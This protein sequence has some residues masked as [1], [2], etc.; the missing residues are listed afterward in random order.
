VKASVITPSG[1]I[2]HYER[3]EIPSDKPWIRRVVCKPIKGNSR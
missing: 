2:Y 1:A 3:I